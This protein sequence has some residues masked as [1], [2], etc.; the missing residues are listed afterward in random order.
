L[1]LR[2]FVARP[3][4]AP[5]AILVASQNEASLAQAAPQQKH[6]SRCGYCCEEEQSED[7]EH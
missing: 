1:L 7:L 5:F 6:D 2:G 4:S 3:T